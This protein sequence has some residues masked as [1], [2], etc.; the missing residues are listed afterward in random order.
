MKIGLVDADLMWRLRTNGRRFGNTKADVYPN[1]V[2]MKLAAYH[3]A[4]GDS[5]DWYVG[6]ERYDRVYVCKV[7]SDTPDYTRRLPNAK[8]IFFGGTG[9]C[10][11]L[12]N[13]R[14]VYREPDDP[15]FISTLPPEIEHIMPD[16]SI[17]P[18]VTDTAYG[19]LSR[20]CPRGCSFCHVAAKEGRRSYKVADLS[21][22]YR[23][24]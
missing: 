23:G 2:C 24:G 4:Q 15:R 14:E 13:G 20:G 21:E 3:K 8:E 9:Y 16:Y 17:Y 22:W 18:M 1:L 12:E 10:V 11:S 7:F 6:L 5:V 19:F